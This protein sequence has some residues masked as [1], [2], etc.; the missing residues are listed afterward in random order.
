MKIQ[1]T[2]GHVLIDES[3]FGLVSRHAWHVNESKSGHRYACGVVGGER[4]RMHRYLFGLKKGDKFVVDHINHDGLD[5]RRI[6]LRVVTGMENC[7]NRKAKTGKKYIGVFKQRDKF[8]ARARR[9][10]ITYYLGVFET[11]EEARDQYESFACGFELLDR[12]LLTN[13][14]RAA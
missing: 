11:A 2:G 7:W 6:N 8:V 1:I 12:A 5:N 10:G 14:A 13:V 9:N 3:D 4:V